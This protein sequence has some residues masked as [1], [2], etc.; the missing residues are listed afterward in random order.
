M[1]SEPV[2]ENSV[3]SM[4]LREFKLLRSLVHEH[5]GIWL[6]D[7]K[8]VMLASRLSRRLRHHGLTS[9]ADYYEL[10]QRIKYC[11]DE[12]REL[13]N[14]VT[15]NKTSFF[16]EQHHFEFLSG[17]VIPQIRAESARGPVRTIRIWSAACSTGEEPYSIAIT[18]LEA[19]KAPQRLNA[20]V[21]A[22]AAPRRTGLQNTTMPQCSCKIEVVA[23]DIDT[24]VL[25]TAIRG[26]YN[27]DSLETVDIQLQRKYFLR[28]TGDMQ[29]KVKI[30]PEAAR[31]V[32]FQRINLMDA[33]WCLDD[34]FD[35]IFFRNALIYFNQE[36]QNVFLRKMARLL[37]P[38]G[39]L[40]LGNSEH[41]PWLSDI[42][43][44]LKQT[45]YRLR[46]VA[47]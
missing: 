17:T 24:A 37:K 8:Q 45:M 47:Q 42:L 25:E 5:S 31:L 11:S 43:M 2:P 22:Q 14:C 18:L 46:S 20:R 44:P 3:F 32:Q 39:Y 29:G 19:L 40:F 15:T 1:L 33:N 30:K 27:D 34:R 4:D 23:S 38:N 10:V 41:I 21:E 26:V 36:T 16:R 9:Y 6:R 35:A 13:I 28:G 12:M 7:G